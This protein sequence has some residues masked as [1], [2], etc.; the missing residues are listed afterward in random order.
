MPSLLPTLSPLRSS[1]DN[2][3]TSPPTGNSGGG[4]NNAPSEFAVSN[5]SSRSIDPADSD[6]EEQMDPYYTDRRAPTMTP[7]MTPT[8]MHS[9]LPSISPRSSS[10]FSSHDNTRHSMVSTSM[11]S[12]S[13]SPSGPATPMP[14][15]TIR[16]T[17]DF[18]FN[19]ISVGQFYD[20]LDDLGRWRE[21]KICKI[22][23]ERLY[24]S[25]VG[26]ASQSHCCIEWEMMLN[27]TLQRRI[28]PLYSHS[29]YPRGPIR[30][31]QCVEVRCNAVKGRDVENICGK[32][33]CEA[34]IL[35]CTSNR[36]MVRLDGIRGVSNRMHD[37]W[38]DRDDISTSIRPLGRQN[39][40]TQRVFT[41]PQPT[42][43]PSSAVATPTPPN[44]FVQIP[45]TKLST[46]NNNGETPTDHAFQAYEEALAASNL[47]II[48]VEGDGNCLFRTISHQLYGEEKWHTLVRQ[49]CI[50]YMATEASFY[51]GFVEGG[52]EEFE[53][54]LASKR[55]DG[56]W[57]DDPE[58]AALCELYSRPCEIWAYDP[59]V[60]A[61]RLRTL[62]ET[63]AWQG[64]DGGIMDGGR[65]TGTNGGTLSTSVIVPF[66][67][68]YYGGGHYDSIVPL[69]SATTT[70]FVRLLD[71]TPGVYEER[72]IAQ[73][74]LRRQLLDDEASSTATLSNGYNP[75]VTSTRSSFLPS[76][77]SP[78]SSQH[79]SQRSDSLE[80][81][82]SVAR[83]DAIRECYRA[84]LMNELS[85]AVEPGHISKLRPS[86]RDLINS[87]VQEVT[88]SMDPSSLVADQAILLQ[89]AVDNPRSNTMVDEKNMTSSQQCN[90]LPEIDLEDDIQA[91][92][93]ASTAAAAE[94]DLLNATLRASEAE[95]FAAPGTDLCEPPFQSPRME[96]AISPS[97]MDIP[98]PMGVDVDDDPE[99]AYALALS[100]EDEEQAF[101]NAL[102]ASLRDSE[103]TQSQ[104]QSS[105]HEELI[106]LQTLQRSVCDN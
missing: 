94:E 34:T 10:I 73:T 35:D 66:R 101:R 48:S 82:F 55:C 29:Y 53:R 80:E 81:S 57:G 75:P 33:W 70:G 12:P 8:R 78:G 91:A 98:S 59:A 16:T 26:C 19:D 38:I 56:C 54:Y 62:H 17:N 77:V 65:P 6:G 102:S 90:S 49:Y 28:A 92:I 103:S 52:I 1:S 14:S 37:C 67:L 104:Q 87:T 95:Y 84:V 11:S 99:L 85:N 97:A 2:L 50:D 32:E 58:I 106:I 105:L 47:Q 31:Q 71:T 44:R 72:V 60:G 42:N 25:F 100:N 45:S 86:Q 3:R 40:T 13:T 51:S 24:I 93:A 74:R 18:T 41:I 69:E 4:S 76:L 61:R 43:L 30:S 46:I 5:L 89:S 20:I 27:G 39:R 88:A 9:I 68:S 21:G 96:S 79:E 63:T 23:G 7:T 36:I 22:Q 64:V 83:E 15:R